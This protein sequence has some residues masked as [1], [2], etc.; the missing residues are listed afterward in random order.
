LLM[1]YFWG[2]FDDAV[3]RRL[4]LP[5]HLGM[6]IALFAILP[7]FTKPIV[8]RSLVV[9]ALVG[10]LTRSVPSMAAHAYSQEYLPGREVAWRRE[11]MAAQPQSDY[12]AIDNDSTLWV[13]HLVCASNINRAKDR[14]EDIAFHLRNRTFSDIFVFQRFNINPETNEMTLREGDDLGPAFVLEPVVEKRMRLLTLSRI[15]RVKEI[16]TNQGEISAPDP[17]APK[18]AKT[19]AEIDD[20]RRRFYEAFM[21]HLP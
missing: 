9:I 13:T 12:L 21:Q 16:R 18:T 8:L 14:R 6:V 15:S 5:T 4:S 7:Q 2:K 19:R 1:A 20:G 3:I 17:I 11:F 10:L